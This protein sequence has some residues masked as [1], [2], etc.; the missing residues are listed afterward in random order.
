M[1]Q[2]IPSGSHESGGIVSGIV[3]L[4]YLA[5]KDMINSIKVKVMDMENPNNR[6][7]DTT[8]RKY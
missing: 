7:Y 6:N 5:C 8:T 3:S 1:I 4:H 2:N